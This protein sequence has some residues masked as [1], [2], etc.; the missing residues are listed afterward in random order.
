MRHSQIEQ[1]GHAG[2]GIVGVQGRQHQM[3]GQGRLH[4]HFRGGQIA[5]LADHDDVG[6]LAQQGAN[7]LGEAQVDG[8]LYLHLIEFGDD[9]FDRILDG[10]DVDL[11]AGE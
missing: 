2:G 10:A 7:A 11:G 3:T 9:H 8:R 4:R 5:N 6:I 1:T